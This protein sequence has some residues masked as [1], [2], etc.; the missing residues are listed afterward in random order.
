MGKKKVIRQTKEELLKES[1]GGASGASTRKGGG[2]SRG[3]IERGRVYIQASLN[4]TIVTITDDKGNTIA[5]LSAGSVGF[6]GPKKATPFAAA[7][8]VEA[9]AEKVQRSGPVHVDVFVRGIGKGRDSAVRTLVAK[10]FDLM[11]IKDVTPIPH[12]GPRP[13]KVRRV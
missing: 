8:V 2:A 5:W 3:R 13:K 10:G 4:N 1:E 12:N 11:S 7:K 6:S 9:I